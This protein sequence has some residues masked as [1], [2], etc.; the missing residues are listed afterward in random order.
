[1]CD[2]DHF[3]RFN[4]TWGHQIGDQVIRFI[5]GFQPFSDPSFRLRL[6]RGKFRRELRIV[7]GIGRQHAN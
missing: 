2:I 6:Q 5:A 3:K 1:M 4:D 7:R